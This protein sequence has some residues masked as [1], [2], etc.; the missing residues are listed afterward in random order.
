M[1]TRFTDVDVFEGAC[2]PTTRCTSLVSGVVCTVADIVDL[3]ML[4]FSTADDNHAVFSFSF[5]L[6]FFC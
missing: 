1:V 3:R 2:G 6:S 5:A 4:V